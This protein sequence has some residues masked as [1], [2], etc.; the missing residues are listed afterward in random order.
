MKQDLGSTDVPNGINL[1]VQM[2]D[3]RKVIQ[4]ANTSP[5]Y[6]KPLASAGGSFFIF[7]FESQFSIRDTYCS[8]FSSCQVSSILMNVSLHAIVNTDAV[9]SRNVDAYSMR[10]RLLL[11]PVANANDRY[12]PTHTLLKQ[13][14]GAST[15]TD[16]CYL[17]LRSN[18]ALLLGGQRAVRGK[19]R[20]EIHFES[21][22]ATS[23]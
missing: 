11:F 8:C 3:F 14:I 12:H 18:L 17:S 1:T 10:F 6:F 7:C 4:G 20:F 5:L 16:I 22:N 2:Q 15:A 21:I 9:P 19:L 23:Q 13:F